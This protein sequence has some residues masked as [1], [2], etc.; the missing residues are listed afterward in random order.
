[1][2]R[3]IYF[4]GTVAILNCGSVIAQA[5]SIQW[6]RCYGGSLFENPGAIIK[7]GNDFIFTGYTIS[8]D[9]DVNGNHG[10][11]CLSTSC[12]DAWIVKIDSIGTIKWQKCLG[13]TSQEA[14][15]NLKVDRSGNVIV[16]CSAGS[17]DGDVT[18]NHGSS[19]FWLVKLD[20][21][22]S[23][24][25]QKCYGGIDGDGPYSLALTNDNGYIVVGKTWNN[26][27][28]DVTGGHNNSSSN[29]ITDAWVIK[30]DSIGNLEWQKCL[31]GS[32]NEIAYSVI[33][34]FNGHFIIA[35]TANSFDGDVVGVHGLIDMWIVELDTGGNVINS[36]CFGGSLGDAA[37]SIEQSIDSGYI[38]C[39]WTSS[40]DGD[41][42]CMNN[43]ANYWIVKL[44]QYLNIEWQKCLGG[45]SND[46]AN[47]INLTF[48]GGYIISGETYSDDG[49]VSNNYAPPNFWI[50]KLNFI[51]DIE[52]EKSI[53]GYSEDASTSIVQ[54]KD[55]GYITMGLTYSNDGDVN[56]N[57]G[58]TDLWIVKL[59]PAPTDVSES[60]SPLT[61]FRVYVDISKSFSMSFYANGNEDA[62]V[63][64][65]NLMG[66][67]VFNK[68]LG[69]KSGFNE[70]EIY[71]GDLKTG[72]Y[73]ICLTVN[74]I[75][76][77]KKIFF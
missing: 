70:T 68:S 12:N 55:S 15:W 53:G 72:M 42:N 76:M 2:R 35:G 8:N 73:F 36:K 32:A 74:G 63:S 41:V 62:Q 30:V 40:S 58:N 31:G 13:G 10:G 46:I 33:Q 4:V 7:V 3:L 5:P 28:G 50:V 17:I 45:S 60:S 21:L 49:D 19:D 48:D 71:P 34:S 16:A 39:G 51:G 47:R 14:A 26:N 18:G 77:V 64:I 54:T 67:E 27:S 75:P 37:H 66:Q 24:I 38:V 44:D 61:D 29:D 43:D 56:G 20:S 22:G 69:V 25:W 52:W 57:H 6:Q 9:G 59:S 65:R 1:M 23:I 11:L